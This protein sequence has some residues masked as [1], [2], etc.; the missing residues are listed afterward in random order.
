M[1]LSVLE[2]NMLWSRSLVAMLL[3]GAVLLTGCYTPPPKP[4]PPPAIVPATPEQAMDIQSAIMKEYPT[5]HVGHVS[6]VDASS[7]MAA[8]VGIPIGDVHKNDSIQFVDSQ[9]IGIANGTVI[10]ADS[11]NP[12]FPTLVVD[13]EPTAAGRAPAAGDLAIYI[14]PKP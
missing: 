14:P 11:S 2:P 4:T 6:A 7:H 12:E 8:I 13:Y 1:R 5:A 9:D 3:P 10:N